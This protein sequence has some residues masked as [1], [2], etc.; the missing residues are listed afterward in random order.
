MSAL[1]FAISLVFTGITTRL[2][3]E[4]LIEELTDIY[5]RF[6]EICDKHDALRI[7]TIGDAYMA[8]TGLNSTNTDHAKKM[9]NV[10]L[11][12]ISYLRERNTQ[13]Q[14]KWECRIGINSGNVIA[15]IIGKSRFSYDIIGMDVNI[16]SRVESAGEK[17]AV[18]ITA[19]TKNLLNDQYK[20]QTLGNKQLKGTDDMEL[21]IVEKA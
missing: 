10:G 12:I 11:D 8:A 18:T 14:Q 4:F 16:A 6:D 19:S 17:M 7:K 20:F 2:S 5:G 9:V 1:C 21:F 3:P 15:G 13:A